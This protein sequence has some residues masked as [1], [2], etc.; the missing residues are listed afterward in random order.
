MCSFSESNCATSSEV[1]PALSVVDGNVVAKFVE[2]RSVDDDCHS[3]LHSVLPYMMRGAL[4]QL[5]KQQ[6]SS[7]RELLQSASA[8]AFLT[9]TRLVVGCHRCASD[10]RLLSL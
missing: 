7:G 4:A 2:T 8:G 3:L 6:S 5:L 1:I 9:Q 10:A